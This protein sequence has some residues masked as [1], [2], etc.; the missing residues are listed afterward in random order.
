MRKVLSF[1]IILL[2]F[3]TFSCENSKNEIQKP[4][5]KMQKTEI[6]K[7]QKAEK[8][9]IISKTEQLFIDAGLI[10]VHTLDTTIVV[11]LKYSTTDNFLGMIL[12]DEGFNKCYLQTL[13][14]E[15]LA[16]AQKILHDTMPNHKLKIFDAS[17]PRHIQQ[18]MWD[19]IKVPKRERGKYV[20]NP[21]PGSLHNFGA[22]V[23]ATIVDENNTELDMG[24]EFDDFT[25]LASTTN[26][27]Q[28]I[29]S[30]L[31]TQK[32]VENRRLLRFCMRKAGFISLPSEWWHFNDCS[33]KLAV[34]KY[35][36][37][38]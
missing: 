29:A 17:R 13:V 6:S 23:D 1:Q 24:T 2:I 4:I 18:L 16:N 20:S 15:K 10:D 26:E 33:R 11:E 25:D 3:F 21:N 27:K 14:A 37:V 30:G 8:Q 22:A 9:Y 28:K 38:E 5:Q 34:E 12:Y 35:S 32:Q 36:L 31:L 19:S 7:P